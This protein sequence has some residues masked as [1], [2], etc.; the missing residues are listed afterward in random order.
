MQRTFPPSSSRP[1]GGALVR[2]QAG[3]T[4]WLMDHRREYDIIHACDFDT[5]LPALWCRQWG[6]VVIYD[7]FDFYADHLRAT[8]EW[9]K[10]LIRRLDLALIHQADAVILADDSRKE[11]IVGAAPRRLRGGNKASA[12][13]CKPEVLLHR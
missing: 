8:P 7:I 4:R 3:L 11:Q 13:P 9:V 1:G 6:K 10:F 2:W 12:P 5:I